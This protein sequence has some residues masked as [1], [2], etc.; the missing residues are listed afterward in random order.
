MLT[1]SDCGSQHFDVPMIRAELAA[2]DPASATSLEQRT[3]GA[4]NEKWGNLNL[5]HALRKDVQWMKDQPLMRVE[6]IDVKGFMYD[7]K[8]GEVN[9]V[10]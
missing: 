7:I 4:I 9:R 5:E 6:G 8:S 3:F 10:V 1:S 2:R